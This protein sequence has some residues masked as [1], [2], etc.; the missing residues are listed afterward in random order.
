MTCQEEPSSSCF[1]SLRMKYLISSGYHVPILFFIR[2]FFNENDPIVRA[3]SD[4][5]VMYLGSML[6]KA[7]FP[8]LHW[9]RFFTFMLLLH[10]DFDWRRRLYSRDWIRGENTV[11]FQLLL[12]SFVHN[13]LEIRRITEKSQTFCSGRKVLLKSLKIE[14]KNCNWRKLG[15]L[16]PHPVLQVLV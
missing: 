5:P 3:K 1:P 14:G 2:L 10:H 13:V 16:C 8:E 15:N 12:L 4:Y 9:G 7:A 11:F 6:S